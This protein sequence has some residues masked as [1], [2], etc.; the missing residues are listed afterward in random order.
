VKARL[1]AWLVNLSVLLVALM[2][3]L[4]GFEVVLRLFLP[5]KLYRFP[6]GLF[7]N[8]PDLVFGLAPGFHGTLK[9]PE[10]TT[11]VRINALGLRG[12][13]PGSKAAGDLRVLGLGDSFAS[14]FNM[15]EPQTFLSV[16]EASLRD[17]IPGRSVEV[18]NAGT[19][20]YGT[21][22]ELRLFKRLA[23]K[24]EPD[25]AILCVYVGNDLENN[26]NPSEGVV[27]DGFLTERQR[28]LGLLPYSLRTWLQRNSMAYVFLWRAWGQVRPWF[29]EPRDDPLKPDK[30]LFAREQGTDQEA[31]YRVTLPI[32]SEFKAETRRRGIP[33]LL[34]LIPTEY[35]VYPERFVEL[36]RK[37]GLDPSRFD[38][39]LPQRRW[40]EMASSAGI[41]VLD[42]LPTLRGR[43]GGP[44]LYMSLD[45]HLSVEGNHLAG[46]AIAEAVKSTLSDHKAEVAP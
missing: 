11:D 30:E 25:M 27:Q 33:S 39:E 35:Q 26:A 46:V 1:Q 10:Y 23:P 16:A 21:W 20:N 40:T 45:G 37:Q 31:A 14:A 42:L 32:L 13:L 5:Q 17:Q 18:I 19:P 41:P 4:G 38:L 12:P 22:H 7:R 6:E 28:H 3:T 36:V 24:L 34:V 43:A 2:V 44:Y 29:G 8:D 15:S 9:N